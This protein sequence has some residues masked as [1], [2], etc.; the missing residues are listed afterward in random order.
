MTRK[1]IDAAHIIAYQD[2]GHRHLQNG[3]IVID[4]NEIVHVGPAGSWA[5]QVDETIDASGGAA[6]AGSIAAMGTK[7]RS[8]SR[9]TLYGGAAEMS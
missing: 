9:H 7:S 4:G 3:T 6:S 5:G 1:R 2:G 8:S